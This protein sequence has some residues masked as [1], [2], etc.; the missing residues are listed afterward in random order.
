[1]VHWRG[2]VWLA[3]ALIVTVPVIAAA[4]SPL[5]AWR[6][7]VYIGAGLAGIIALAL[8]F[9]QPVLIGFNGTLGLVRARAGTLHR[10]TGIGIVVAVFVHVAGLWVTSPPDV[11]DV[12][13]FRSPTPFGVWGALALWVILGAALVAL[14]RRRLRWSPKRWRYTHAALA[15]LAVVASILHT[16]L[17]E[18]T[19][20]TVSKVLLCGALLV[21]SGAAAWR[22]KR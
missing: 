20:E 15:I 13:L 4:F 22:M 14:A 9:L 12:L 2:M 21:A 3:V 10:M 5:L 6:S 16:L 11:I 7:P 1:M 17:I 18:G 8:M 19:M